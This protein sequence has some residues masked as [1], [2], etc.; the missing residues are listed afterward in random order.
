MLINRNDLIVWFFFSPA[1]SEGNAR[2]FARKIYYKFYCMLR[3]CATDKAFFCTVQRRSMSNCTVPVTTVTNQVRFSLLWFP[4]RAI[5]DWGLA[6]NMPSV[7]FFP[8]P[9]LLDSKPMLQLFRSSGAECRV[10]VN[11]R[12]H[13]SSR[14][15]KAGRWAYSHSQTPY[16][17]PHPT[18]LGSL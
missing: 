18:L 9:A 6:F 16:A 11:T 10:L 1:T 15:S 2:S 12:N 13:C 4:F 14:D 17:T 7:N 5:Q 8:S 3:P